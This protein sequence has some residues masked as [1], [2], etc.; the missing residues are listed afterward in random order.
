MIAGDELV[1]NVCLMFNGTGP[2]RLEPRPQVLIHCVA[3]LFDH[4]ATDSVVV[5]VSSAASNDSKCGNN[6]LYT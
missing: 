6:A 3:T 2:H 5:N 4:N 1:V